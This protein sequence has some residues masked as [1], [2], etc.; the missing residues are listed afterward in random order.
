VWYPVGDDGEIDHDSPLLASEDRL[1]VDPSSDVPD[2]YTESQRGQP[3]GFVADSDVMDTWATSSLT[4]Q[5]VTGWVDDPDLFART[6]PMDL[7]P[8]GPEIIRTWL[9]DTVVRSWFEHRAL[10]WSATTIN[11]WVLD[12]DRKK[13]SKSKGNVV[14]P[15]PLVEE[16]GSDALRYWACNGRPA[17]DTAVDYGIMKIGRKLAIKLLNVSKFVLNIAGDEDDDLDAV[18]EA[19][20]RSMLSQLADLVDDA[21]AAFDGFDYARAL[22]RT[23]RF[24]WSFCDDY[25]E[26][27]KG[28]AYG[29]A[30]DER[31]RSAAVALRA[32]LSTLQRLFAPILPFVAEEVWSWWQDGSIH[33][34][35]WPSSPSLLGASADPLVY[36]VAADVLGA[37]RKEKSAQKRSLASPV[38]RVV[39]RDTEARLAALAQALDDV[40]EAGK[41][42]T[43]STEPGTELLVKVELAALA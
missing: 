37:V 35:A 17:V 3:R 15:M 29:G 8:Q 27:V 41:I 39:V 11:G 16:Y 13:M 33:R 4:P 42:T 32:A 40:C 36:E 24:F 34:A 9:F 20:D 7:R 26:L 31:A 28:R 1:P 5:I 43:L 2:G 12:P 38:E 25:V 30:G 14:T 6:F 10:P 21:T 22:E 19:L 18:G 23:E